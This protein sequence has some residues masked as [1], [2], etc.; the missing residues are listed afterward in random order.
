M[1]VVWVV[2]NI[3]IWYEMHNVFYSEF[4]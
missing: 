4:W 1:T 2:A 3:L